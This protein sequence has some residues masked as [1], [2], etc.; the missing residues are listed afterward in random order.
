MIQMIGNEDK[1]KSKDRTNTENQ[2]GFSGCVVVEANRSGSTQ[3][4]FHLG[5]VHQVSEAGTSCHHSRTG[6]GLQQGTQR[7]FALPSCR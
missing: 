2:W 6:R 3:S 1:S 5:S 4:D 7:S